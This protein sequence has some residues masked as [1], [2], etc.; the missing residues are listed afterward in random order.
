M[1][2]K[3]RLRVRTDAMNELVCFSELE[4]RL[5]W[6]ASWSSLT[7]SAK[8]LAG[9]SQDAYEE[10]FGQAYELHEWGLADLVW[11][12]EP[13]KHIP[14][15]SFEADI[16]LIELLASEDGEEACQTLLLL[17]ESLTFLEGCDIQLRLGRRRSTP[18][19]V[20]EVFLRQAEECGYYIE[21]EQEDEELW[22]DEDE[23]EDDWYEDPFT[24]GTSQQNSH[25]NSNGNSRSNSGYSHRRTYSWGG[26]DD[27]DCGDTHRKKGSSELSEAAQF[28]LMYATLEWPCSMT[29][30]QKSWHKALHNSHPD[31]HRHDSTAHDRTRLLNLGYEELREVLIL[32][33]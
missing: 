31:K 24:Q 4:D 8:E 27:D 17:M 15:P 12:D 13:S 28:F 22:A 16:D 19:H 29:E 25:A 6:P 20:R 26:L 7:A 1:I 33:S 32:T 23:I 10:V 11:L 30:L 5:L 18:E 2:R 9:P 14:F 21:Y 3:L